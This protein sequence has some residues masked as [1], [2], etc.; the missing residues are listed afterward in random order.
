MQ[1]T[2]PKVQAFFHSPDVVESM[3]KFSKKHTWFP[4]VVNGF[5]HMMKG[6]GKS[7]PLQLHSFAVFAILLIV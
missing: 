5:G 6:S 3:L 2:V 1:D 4:F 7:L